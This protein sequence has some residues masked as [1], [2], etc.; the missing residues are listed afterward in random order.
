MNINDSR[1]GCYVYIC[2]GVICFKN[3]TKE[4]TGLFSGVGIEISCQ[5]HTSIQFEM[6]N[7]TVNNDFFRP[8]V[9]MLKTLNKK[10]LVVT[11]Q[12]LTRMLFIIERFINK[13]TQLNVMLSLVLSPH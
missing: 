3:L 9:M 4:E 2:Y 13:V 1:V 11:S 10:R 12:I 6:K 7:K 8:K 5:R